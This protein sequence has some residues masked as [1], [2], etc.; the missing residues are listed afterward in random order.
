MKPLHT[1]IASLTLVIAGGCAFAA[2]AVPWK[3]ADYAAEFKYF[4]ETEAFTPAQW[5]ELLPEDQ[6][7]ALRETREPARERLQAIQDYYT[8]VMTPWDA[9]QA[10]D[11]AAGTRPE[12]VA[13]VRLWL[14]SERAAA[15]QKKL[16]VTRAALQAAET[17]G[18]TPAQAGALKPYL[19]QETID[20][21]RSL[22]AAEDLQRQADPARRA[23]EV[24]K[25]S[26]NAAI[27]G[28]SGAIGD[29]TGRSIN[30]VF[31]GSTGSGDVSDPVRAGGT[32]GKSYEI[33]RE[34][35]KGAA[36][37]AAG[38]L[39]AYTAKNTA[40][41][42][43]AA[44]PRGSTAATL[45]S[46]A[47]RPP[48]GA[49][50]PP[51]DNKS[52]AWTSDAYGYTIVANGQTATYRNQREAEAAIRA[53]PA[54]SVSKITLYGHGSPGMQTVGNATYEA[55]DTAQLLKG[56]MAPGGVI[57]YSGCNTASI[58]GATLNPAVGISMLT[59]R[60]MYFS[61]PYL[62]DRMSGVPAAQAKEQW[63]KGWD[64]DL[65][66]D[67][68][69]QMRGAIVCG[70]RTFGLVPGRMPGLTRLMGNQ[71]ATTPGYVAGK[72]VCYQ[73]GKEVPAP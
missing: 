6:E 15:M 45:K 1:L 37:G 59:R 58:G 11:Y 31:D 10:R 56:K 69:L 60:L 23:N 36:A 46:A 63:E 38:Q 39:G 70:F 73:D 32:A 52:T 16:S 43:G 17:G 12:D 25:E 4:Q 68:S 65:S 9:Y 61:I 14:G 20:G 3:D 18:L 48:P 7:Q 29:H 71:E 62:Q 40:D 30:K 2:E 35:V 47:P 50:T 51:A 53:L 54:G 55:G 13:A 66:R 44:Q 27:G 34:A 33:P 21:L 24:P 5:R 67:T 64:A 57:Q 42:L 26:V 49:G 28:V 19:T 41:A 8:A 72:T 22:K